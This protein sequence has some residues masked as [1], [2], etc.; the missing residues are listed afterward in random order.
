MQE[1]ELRSQLRQIID[2]IDAGRLAVPRPPGM[3]MRVGGTLCVA[4]LGLGLC[5]CPGKGPIG[6]T[7]PGPAPT[8]TSTPQPAYGVPAP[9]PGPTPDPG[10]VAEYMA[11]DPGTMPPVDPSVRPMYG[12]EP[13]PPRP[14]PAPTST[15]RKGVPP[16]SPDP[17]AVAEYMA[18]G[19]GP[20]PPIDTG[21]RPL[22]GVETVPLR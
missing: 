9:E 19:P 17:G 21:P 13:V 3:M 20:A 6:P 10:A 18:P 22:Y 12:V 8:V 4:A 16:I 7:D 1:Q 5:A 11:P 14:S 15:R 2:D